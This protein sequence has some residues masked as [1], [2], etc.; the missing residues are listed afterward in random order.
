MANHSR[1]EAVNIVH[2]RL[3]RV[4]DFAG[5]IP[6]IIKVTFL[7]LFELSLELFLPLNKFNFLS[8]IAAIARRLRS[9]R[10]Q[11]KFALGRS[12]ICFIRHGL[13]H[14][15][16]HQEQLFYFLEPLVGNL[17]LNLNQLH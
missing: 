17:K 2:C 16:G 9:H 7:N 6:D 10:K 13:K 14:E 12:E 8:D 1:S 4:F 5:F 11:V 3:C 15:L